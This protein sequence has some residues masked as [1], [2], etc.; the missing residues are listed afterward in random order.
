MAIGVDSHKKTLEAAALDGQ[1]RRLECRRFANTPT[2]HQEF[3]E[4]AHAFSTSRVIGIEGSTT[5]GTALARLLLAAGDDVREVP[6]NLTFREAYVAGK[7][8]SDPIDAIAIAR[9]VLREEMLPPAKTGVNEG[10]KLLS[11]QRDRLVRARSAELGRI[12][13][14]MVIVKPGYERSLRIA[15]NNKSLASIAQMVR[16]DTSVRA[17]MIRD[18]IAEVRRLNRVVEKVERRIEALVEETGTTLQE[19]PGIGTMLAAKILGEVGDPARLRSAPGFARLSG[20][21]PVPASSG[22]V[23]R[24]RFDRRGNR[25][26]N[27]SIHMIAVVRCR[28]DQRT[29]DYMAKKRAE[30]KTGKEAMRC[31]KRHIANDLYRRMKAD[32][33]VISKAA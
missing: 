24:H 23:V 27:N 22:Q 13:G 16:G 11:D 12:H 26:L 33:E 32:C 18:S 21:A 30:G 9:V 6:P 2:G 7:G 17:D 14:F 31:L 19:A 4:W 29:K 5:Y 20:V 1:G 3:L 10:L 15:K 25:V 8:K 28:I